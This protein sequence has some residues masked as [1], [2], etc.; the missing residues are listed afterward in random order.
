MIDIS[1]VNFPSAPQFPLYVTTSHFIIAQHTRTIKPATRHRDQRIKASFN[2]QYNFIFI[3][4]YHTY[5][6]LYTETIV[7]LGWYF[8]AQF[9]PVYYTNECHKSHKNVVCLMYGDWTRSNIKGK[10]NK[11]RTRDKNK[12]YPEKKELKRRENNE[13]I[14]III[15]VMSSILLPILRPEMYPR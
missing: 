5:M 7:I 4:I 2:K 15:I 10:Q 12:V 6:H 1:Q 9:T 14:V 8:M 3:V 11:T 13:K